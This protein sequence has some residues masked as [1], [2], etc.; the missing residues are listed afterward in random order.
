MFTTIFDDLSERGFRETA[1][2]MAHWAGS[3]PPHTQCR[4]CVHFLDKGKKGT[5]GK[6]SQ[7]MRKK[8]PTFAGYF[9]ACKYFGKR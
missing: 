8:G 9:A 2:G 1:A 5:C 4:E 7:M 3:G 6:Y